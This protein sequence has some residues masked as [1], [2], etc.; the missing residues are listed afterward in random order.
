[1][2]LLILL[3][4]DYVMLIMVDSTRWEGLAC[5]LPVALTVLLALHTS[6][7]SRT[8]IRIAAVAAFICGAVG[9]LQLFAA[10]RRSGASSS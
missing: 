7:S 1:M 5:T 3:I 9:V 4:V 10:H 2:L 8:T 6:G